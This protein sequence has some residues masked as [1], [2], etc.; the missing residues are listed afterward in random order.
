MRITQDV[1]VGE[2]A[3]AEPSSI[4]VFESLGIDYCCGGKR[5]LAD[6][7]SRIGISVDD[8][9][10]RITQAER[11][12]HAPALPAWAQARLSAIIRHI[13]EHHHAYIRSEAPR[14][15][16]LLEKVV[17]RHGGTHP[18][19]AEIQDLFLAA[20]QELV[21]HALKE[22]Q[23]LFPHIIRMEEAAA[24]GQPLPPAF[25][26]SISM[27]IARML[28]DHDDAGALFAR[29]NQFAGGYV[30]PEGACATF[31]ALYHGLHEFERDLHEH[32][33]LE[34][35]VLFPRAIALERGK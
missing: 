7:C 25:F 4:R 31:R 21:T 11:D 24:A 1:T 16:A 17:A 5:G 22:E 20:I 10:S 34:N 9:I 15:S 35:N 32:V 8:A 33:H 14:I 28:A 18:E 26:G 13:V 30:P 29:M 2:I 19:M 12:A 3:A 6:A 23:V 27:P